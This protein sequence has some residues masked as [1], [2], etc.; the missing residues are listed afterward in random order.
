LLDLAL[1]SLL[2]T[3]AVSALTYAQ[4]LYLLPISLFGMSVAAAELP[5]LSSSAPDDRAVVRSRLE[6]GLERVAFF[7]VPTAVAYLLLGAVVVGALYQRGDFGPLDTLQV[8]VVLAGYSVGLNATTSSRLLQSAFYARG[9]SRTPAVVSVVRVALSALLGAVLMLQLDRLAVTASGVDLVGSLPA[10]APVEDALRGDGPSLHRLGA[11]GLALAAGL[12]AWL[13]YALLRRRLGARRGELR[14]G[15]SARGPIALGAAA[16]G[17]VGLGARFL[18]G[19]AHPLLA[20][21]LVGVPAGLAYLAV[22]SALGVGEATRLVA[23]VRRR[24]RGR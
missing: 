12:S 17:L 9:E 7:V 4:V 16:A 10:L 13:E 1:A 14:W 8:W 6:A 21:P 22:T 3:G 23:L 15:G 24:L 18:V 2:A 5:E 11:A 19:D 20:A